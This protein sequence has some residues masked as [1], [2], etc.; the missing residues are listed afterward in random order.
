MMSDPDQESNPPPADAPGTQEPAA[1]AGTVASHPVRF[2]QPFL[3]APTTEQDFNTLSFDL[4]AIACL[5]LPDILFEFD[6]SFPNPSVA[7]MLTQIAPLR[8][9][10]ANAKGQ[11]P[12]LSVFGHADPSGDDDYNKQLSGRRAMAIYAVI[13]RDQ[14]LWD[15]LFD[16]P[17][18]GDDWKAKNVAATMRAST[19]K[20]TSTPRAE[21]SQAYMSLLCPDALEKSDFLGQGGDAKGKADFQGCSE[22]N[23]VLLLSK[24]EN[25]ALSK[26]QRNQENTPNRRVIIFMFRVGMKV[27]PSRWPCPT[28]LAGPADCRKRFFGPPKTGELRRTPGTARREF[29]DTPDTFACR[30]Y[31][32]VARLSP[33]EGGKPVP[34]DA[35]SPVISFPKPEPEAVRAPALALTGA[36]VA[37]GTTAGVAPATRV[38]VVK[39][40]HTSVAR[41]DVDLTTDK[42][43]D[44]QGTFTV[45]PADRIG[46]F[47]G[48]KKLEFKNG[49]NVF[50]ADE[51]R[52]GVTLFAEGAKAS[53]V[54]DDVTLTLSLS[55]GTKRTGPPATAK[56]TAVEV[57]LDICE[58]RESTAADPPALAQPP[59]ATPASGSK[60]KDKIFGGRGLPEQT[61]G[62]TSE[63]ALLLVRRIQPPSFNGKLVLTAIGDSVRAFTR[64]LPADDPAPK[65]PLPK[66]HV[67]PAANVKDADGRFFAEGIKA[68]GALRDTGF[69][70]GIEGLQEDADRVAITVVHAEIVSKLAPADVPTIALVPEKPERK[71]RSAFFAAPIIIGVNYDVQL[72]PH[73]EIA[74]TVGTAGL[75]FKWSTPAAASKLT[76]TDVAKEIVKLKGKAISGAQDDTLVDLIVD[77]DIGK[78]KVT[79]KLTIVNF[80]IDS[81]ISGE[82]PANTDDINFIRNP[83]VIPILRGAAAADT[84]QAP[85]IEITNAAAQAGL[86]WTDDDPRIAWRIIGLQAAEAGKAKYEGKADFL[87]GEPARRGTKIQIAGQALGSPGDILVEAWSGGFPYA[88]FRSHVIEIRRLKY[89]VNRIRTNAVAATATKPAILAHGPTRSH[90]D[91]LRHIKV[92]NIYLRQI[93]IELIQDTSADV[94]APP[95]GN[96]RVGLADTDRRVVSVA[97]AAGTTGHF[98]VFVSDLRMTFRASDAPGADRAVRVNTRNEIIAFAYIESLAASNTAL[99]QTQLWPVNH[100]PGRAIRD[101]GIPSTSLLRRT[102]I[103]G[104]TPVSQFRMTVIPALFVRP[105]NDSSAT[106]HIDLLWGISVPTVSIDN[107]A[108]GVNVDTAYG[109]TLAH[110]VGHVLGLGHRIAAGDAFADGLTSAGQKNVMFPGSNIAASENF[111]IIQAKAIRQSEVLR[112]NP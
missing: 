28:A 79:H 8:Q 65:Q 85:K 27:D 66:R 57:T 29:A 51:L 55:G 94:A 38:V 9:Q 46:F 44:G 103:P 47:L 102:G 35:V 63:R 49:D 7:A 73:T 110:E 31:D 67:F 112:R 17:H 111:D 90:A 21:L 53:S 2:F 75:K 104:S 50:T 108:G 76:L 4:V 93:G 40:P 43:F 12:P 13:T 39:K 81:V 83:A 84:K 105:K 18:G 86:N 23:P 107:V 58:P 78:F 82:N 1:T 61:E 42:P 106:R 41:I 16:H 95:P 59:A 26:A 54:M 19:A 72:R 64:E 60:P 6:S 3:V 37:A 20:P 5:Q 11:L 56:M 10:H 36:P 69:Q 62:K 52:V 80:E 14:T 101:K 88:M 87:A 100:L 98:D 96:P 24:T 45:S 48:T 22:F 25:A 99:A 32:R 109:S 91:A 71:T 33:C 97:A 68:S 70:L 15:H 74:G 77:A 30:F 34:R 89:R 92:A